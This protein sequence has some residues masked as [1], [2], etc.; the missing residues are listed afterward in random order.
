MR[1]I[2]GPLEMNSTKRTFGVT[3]NPLLVIVPGLII[4]TGVG[5]IWPSEAIFRPLY[6]AGILCLVS[7]VIQRRS[8]ERSPSSTQTI[9]EIYGDRRAGRWHMP[10]ASNLLAS[11][12][13][14]LTVAA[15]LGF[16]LR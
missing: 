13:V 6:M 7:I 8:Q 16:L 5:A 3:V 15:F 11:V 14:G 9:G 2:R 10:L 12:G 4:G 1:L